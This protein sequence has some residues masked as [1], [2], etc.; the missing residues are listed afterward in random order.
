MLA[1]IDGDVLLY[2]AMWGSDTLKQACKKFDKILEE[3]M[4]S[5]FSEDYAIAVGGPSNFRDVLYCDYKRS[6][7][8][9][10]SKSIR[11]DWFED[12]KS[13]VITNEG[14]YQVEGCEADD[15]VRI[16]AE[17][18]RAVNKPFVVVTVDKD[19]NCIPG[20]HYNPIKRVLFNM[21]T[22]E[23]DLFYWTQV[24]TGDVVDNIPGIT[25][26]GPKKAEK[27]LFGAST[28]ALRIE[29]VCRAYN[30]HCGEEG[31]D[32]MLLNGKLLHMWRTY[33][34]HFVIK[35]SVYDDAIKG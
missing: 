2:Q 26:I 5:T 1:I 34:D 4:E 29:A 18:C 25:G 19:L 21:E 28:R 35:R 31:F 8:R 12:L 23:A 22:D 3:V 16:W 13:Y 9:V 11:A 15:V 17:E 24:L 7:G 6:A 33:G 10:K 14:T 32:R 30:E 20:W 27:I